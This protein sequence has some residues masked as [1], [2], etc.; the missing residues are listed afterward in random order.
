MSKFDK[1][2]SD[3]KREIKSSKMKNKFSGYLDSFLFKNV[4]ELSMG[5]I[6]FLNNTI[7]HGFDTIKVRQQAKSMVGDIAM[8]HKNNVIQKCIV[9]LCNNI[10]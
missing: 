6:E 2:V 3:K 8:Y 5:W 1:Y 10:V 9:I 4:K 7:L